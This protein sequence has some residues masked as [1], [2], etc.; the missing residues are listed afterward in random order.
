MINI[1]ENLDLKVFK[2]E[3]DINGIEKVNE[4]RKNLLAIK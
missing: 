2:Y 4:I 3:N 1:V